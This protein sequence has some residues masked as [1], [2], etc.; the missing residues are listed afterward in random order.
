MRSLSVC[1]GYCADILR[2]RKRG[3]DPLAILRPKLRPLLQTAD[4]QRV[5]ERVVGI[6]ARSDRCSAIRAERVTA[7]GAAVRGFYVDLGLPGQ[8]P[9]CC[10]RRVYRDAKRGSGE[11]LTVGAVADVGTLRVDLGLVCDLAAV[12][13]TFDFHGVAP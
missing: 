13:R 10:T 11:H 1:G 8:Q 9:E 5:R 3:P 12:A 2:P 6:C 4:S 7:P